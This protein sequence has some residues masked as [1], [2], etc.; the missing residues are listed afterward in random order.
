[1]VWTAERGTMVFLRV[2]IMTFGAEV[3]S[4][5]MM[6]SRCG[7]AAMP[8]T[9]LDRFG[10][11]VLAAV[12]PVV[13]AGQHVTGAGGGVGLALDLDAVAAR[14]NVHAQPL[15]DGDQMPVVIAEQRAEQ[16]R[17]LELQL[18]PGAAAFIGGNCGKVAAGHQAA[19][20]SQQRAPVM[21]LG[22]AATNV[23]SIMSP[24]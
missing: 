4:S 18:E 17:L 8:S 12:E 23:T 6:P 24:A 3:T 21:L 9:R 5:W 11:D 13:E 1:M 22:P 14:R 7:W 15:L 16:V 2:R 10:I 20:R 19:T